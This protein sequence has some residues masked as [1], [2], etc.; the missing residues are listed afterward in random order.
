M[1]KCEGEKSV[2]ET[3]SRTSSTPVQIL[4]GLW[5]F[6]DPFGT[7]QQSFV[8]VENREIEL[9]DIHFTDNLCAASVYLH[10]A[11]GLYM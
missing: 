10:R 2:E 8:V 9:H 7:G 6:G 11:E 5:L 3:V 1:V 4:P